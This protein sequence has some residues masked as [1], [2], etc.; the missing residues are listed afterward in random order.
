MDRDDLLKRIRTLHEITFGPDPSEFKRGKAIDY[1]DEIT[2]NSEFT[3]IFFYGERERTVEEMAD[4]AILREKLFAEGGREAVKQHVV[5]LML[6]VLENPPKEISQIHSA[7]EI[8]RHF[9]PELAIK[10]KYLID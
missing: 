4:E 1:I 10:Y 7:Y 8:L 9:A 2:P 5:S 3:K 6:P